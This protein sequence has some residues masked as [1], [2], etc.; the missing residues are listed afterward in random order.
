MTSLE[1]SVKLNRL[2]LLAFLGVDVI[3]LR[4]ESIDLVGVTHLDTGLIDPDKK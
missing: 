2:I 1:I 4:L 3:R